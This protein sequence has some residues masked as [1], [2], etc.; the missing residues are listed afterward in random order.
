M[1][2]WIF[3]FRPSLHASRSCF[4]SELMWPRMFSAFSAP[5]GWERVSH[6]IKKVGIEERTPSSTGTEK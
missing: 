5:E 1:P 6:D 4:S 2:F 3:P